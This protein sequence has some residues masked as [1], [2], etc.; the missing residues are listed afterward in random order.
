MTM[1]AGYSAGEVARRLG[2]AVTTLR[3][4]HQRYGLG[5][6]RHAPGEHR[7]YTDDDLA[8]FDVM[9]RLTAQGLPAAEAARIAL[10]HHAG[11]AAV[12]AGTARD[13]GGNAIPVGRA[14][15]AA[16]GLAR[17][18]M[19]LDALTMIETIAAAIRDRGVV[20]TWDQILRPVLVGIGERHGATGQFVEV[21]HLL[22]RSISEVLAAVPRPG[23]ASPPRLLLACAA[24]EQHSL[25]LEALAAAL[26]ERGHSSRMLGA[27]VPAAALAAAIRRTRPTTVVVWSHAHATGD[28]HHLDAGTRQRHRPVLI[29]AG[30]GW[31]DLP[32]SVERPATLADTLALLLPLAGG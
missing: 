7:R 32:A 10:A 22:S 31:P 4:W 21:E 12:R 14:D 28:P 9:A 26:A 5:P 8:R 29:A 20:D 15:P 18:A 1:G 24:E 30:P 27:R 3:T 19:R 6:T 16:R 11:P 23:P 25:P 17:A 13:G 2:V